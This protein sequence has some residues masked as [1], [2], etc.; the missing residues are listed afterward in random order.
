VEELLSG[1]K[2]SVKDFD[3]FICTS[4]SLP[5]VFENNE[6]KS[7]EGSF[8]EGAGLRIKNKDKI[9]FSSISDL[10]S[11]E[12]TAKNA[13]DTSGLG[14]KAFFD[15]PEQKSAEKDLGIFSEDLAETSPEAMLAWGDH[16]IRNLLKLNNKLK[17]NVHLE[18]DVLRKRLFNSAGLGLDEK[19]TIIDCSVSI[20]LAQEK[21]FLEIWDYFSICDVPSGEKIQAILDNIHFLYTHAQKS[22]SVS[23]GPHKVYFTPKAFSTLMNLFIQSFNGKLFE[24]KISYFC[25][26]IDQSFIDK[27]I[28][29][30]D[31]PGLYGY[32]K[33]SSFDG[34]G[35]A[36][37]TIALIKSGVVKAFPLDLQTAGKMGL[38]SNGHS[39]RSTTALPVPGFTNIEFNVKD[40]TLLDKRKAII[41]DMDEGLIVD[42]FLGAGQS[43]I[44]GGEFSS[45]VELGYVVKNGKIAGRVKNCMITGN[46]FDFFSDLIKA[47]DVKSD[48]SGFSVP[49]VL[50]DKISVKVKE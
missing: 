28:D 26:K 30:I 4:E 41:S 1:I 13:L 46:M 43:N 38:H 27:D 49:G 5:V 36:P 23:S 40:E 14:E 7:I 10:S 16:Y 25:D 37:Q 15:F 8:H 47:D 44:I 29:I 17:V 24:K 48:Y 20:F 50:F 31:N 34:D 35:L 42:Q 12:D 6:L 33:S 19:K 32:P 45:N 9:G 11:L 22:A 39:L 18:K 21:N 2:K 3:L